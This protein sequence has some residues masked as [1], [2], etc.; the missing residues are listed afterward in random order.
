MKYDVFS[1]CAPAMPKPG[2]GTEIISLITSQVS[3]EMKNAIVPTPFPAFASLLKGVKVMYCNNRYL[4]LNGQICH[5]IG[6]SGVGKDQLNNVVESICRSF[7]S[8]D[9]IEMQKIFAW[10]ALPKKE[11]EK[12]TRPTVAIFFPPSDTTKPAF[13]QNA[14]ACED[15]GGHAQYFNLPEVEMLDSLCGGR[16]IAGQMLINIHDV[17]HVGALRAT[18]DGV[19][20][21]P[22]M[23]AN[24]NISS[25]EEAAREYYKRDIRK[26]KTG[27]VSFAYKPRGERK[28]KI[29]REGLYDAAFIA[30]LD[31]YL[32][33]LESS[34]GNFIIT[35]LNKI[36]DMLAVE[37][38]KI[39]DL[40]D[41]D[42]LF[43]LSHRCILSA[44]KKGATLWLLNNQ[45][46]TRSIGEFVVW[47]CY[48]DLWSKIQVLG[49]M[50]MPSNSKENVQKSGP[51][52]MLRQLDN[53]FPQSQLEALRT[54]MGKSVSG[55]KHQLDVWVNRGFIEYS[56]QTG[57][58]TKTEKY[59][60][61]VSKNG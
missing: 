43:D 10:Q 56:A 15:E 54:S 19:S 22:V 13:I 36:A 21:N 16:K 2:K 51:K 7:R 1:G 44:W 50:F 31:E 39:A 8:H 42:T 33:R 27:R 23:R 35:P 58:Y 47:F 11:R 55:T 6:S 26:G 46:W 45:T 24:I 48:Y 20:G 29:P 59:F 28:G 3:P 57:L 14:M 37:M 17:K 53:P 34:H 30:Q 4:E 38:V 12:T 60:K 52:N 40:T 18:A 9:E 49:D 25:T 32:K 41:D 5:L 61:R